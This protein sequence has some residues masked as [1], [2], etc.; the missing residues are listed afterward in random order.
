MHEDDTLRRF[1][2]SEP[3]TGRI[4]PLDDNILIEPVDDETETSGGLIIPSSAESG[5]I[6]G[7]V[8]AVGDDS[9]GIAPAT[10]CCTRA[11][12]ASSCDCQ[13]SRSGWSAAT[14]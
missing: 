3:F 4:E 10:R 8:V 11:A 1:E 7:I 2:S 14:S 9:H 12:R 13:A 6:S 5:V